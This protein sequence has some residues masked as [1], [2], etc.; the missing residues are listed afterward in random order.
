MAKNYFL[1]DDSCLGT[2]R[3]LFFRPL[4]VATAYEYLERRFHLVV[5]LLASAAFM[6]L[7]VG[8]MGVVLY[9]PALVLATVTDVSMLACIA[10]MG[11][12]TTVYTVIAGIEAVIWIDVVQDSIL[13]DA[14]FMSLAIVIVQQG[15]F[16]NFISVGI[17]E[18]KLKPYLWN[19]DWSEPQSAGTCDWPYVSL[20]DSLH[21]RSG[22][23]AALPDH[24]GRKVRRS[25][26]LAQ[27]IP[28][29]SRRPVVLH[30]GHRVVRVL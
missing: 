15:D 12:V 11:T 21:Q 17:A 23:R 20:A 22:G 29:H 4:N 18:G 2:D 7:Q 16:S 30:P 8:R 1:V 19:L 10:V 13:L 26:N 28:C 9:L 25:R 6:A 5:R 27:R 24:K 3:G 14:A